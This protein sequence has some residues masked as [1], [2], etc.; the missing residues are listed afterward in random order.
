MMRRRAFIMLLATVAATRPRAARAQ[1]SASPVVGFLGD[2]PLQQAAPPIAAFRQGLDEIGYTEGR[3][4]TIDWR[5]AERQPDRLRALA[6][7][8]VG[9]RV[10]V[11]VS[12]GDRATLAAAA[13]TSTIPIV[14]L[15]ESDPAKSGLVAGPDRPRGNVTG[16][17]WF[18]AD[19]APARFTLLRQ[20]VPKAAVIGLLLDTN[21]ADAV[22]QLPQVQAAADANGL[23]LVVA[24][25]AGAGDIEGAFAALV[26]QQV[27]GLV[28]GVGALFAS[29]RAQL[30]A[31]A[32]RHGVPAIYADHE[33]ACDH[34][35]STW[36]SISRPPRRSA[37]RCRP[38][39][40]PGPTR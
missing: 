5:S 16:L 24:Q 27:G 21:R 8:L 31:L 37:S 33:I 38:I 32:A 22:A 1:P 4:V 10:A 19:P 18:G 14:F 28:V 13:A 7:D 34:P 9:R 40:S 20:L 36:S 23:R 35:R 30:I 26:A 39:W 15:S 6:A 17:S 25:A 2:G 3:N 29:R 12:A 11:I